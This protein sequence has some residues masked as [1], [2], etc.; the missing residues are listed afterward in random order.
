M[1]GDDT[2][3][4]ILYCDVAFTYRH[5]CMLAHS[6]ILY[7]SM[8]VQFS[9]YTYAVQ[10]SSSS[11]SLLPSSIYR[12]EHHDYSYHNKYHHH[13]LI[14]TIIIL[15]VIISSMLYSFFIFMSHLFIIIIAWTN[16]SPLCQYIWSTGDCTYSSRTWSRQGG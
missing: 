7:I 1:C 14:T 8:L 6:Y 4:I 3:I 13:L 5:V 15:D 10:N 16:C 2:Y 12:D 9:F 11:S